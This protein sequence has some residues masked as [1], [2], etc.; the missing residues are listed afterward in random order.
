MHYNAKGSTYVLKWLYL[1]KRYETMDLSVESTAMQSSPARFLILRCEVSILTV[2]QPLQQG[3][4]SQWS[5]QVQG[6]ATKG[7]PQGGRIMAVWNQE[8]TQFPLS[9]TCK[10]CDHLV[11]M[12]LWAAFWGAVWWCQ[13]HLELCRIF[14]DPSSFRIIK[15]FWQPTTDNCKQTQMQYSV[16]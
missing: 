16:R 10:C 1:N 15:S 13:T 12:L 8:C 4:F 2:Q 7:I 3:L 9:A 5:C 14:S 11:C 6:C